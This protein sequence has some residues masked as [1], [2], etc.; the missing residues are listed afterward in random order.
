MNTK[1][2][3]S[4]LLLGI[5]LF[6]N[7]QDKKSNTKMNRTETAQNNLKLLFGE[8]FKMGQ[9]NDPEMMTLLQKYIFGEVFQIGDLDLKTRELITCVNLA[10]MQTMP[11]LK[12]HY[13]AAL[14]V[15]VTPIELREAIYQTASIIGFPKTLN[16]LNVLNE[17]FTEKE[18]ALPLENK[19]T[20][21]DENRYEKGLEIQEP[22]YGNNMK[23]ALKDVPDSMGTDV[24]N[25][26]TAVHFGDFYTRK[27]LDLKTRELLTYCVL[28]TIGAE[29]QLNAHIPANIKLGNSK[30]ILSAAVIQSMPYIGFPPAIKALKIIKDYQEK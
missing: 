23:N 20:V 27:G 2:I 14:N 28:T 17:V 25:F 1:I 18:I 13:A 22:L 6:S 4:L 19:A 5:S 3:L 26:L 24:A 29:T 9:G 10:A 12:G 7:A 11:Q 8:D 16:A 30:E 15:G 21:I